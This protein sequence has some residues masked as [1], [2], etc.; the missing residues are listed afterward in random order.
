MRMRT[1]WWGALGAGLLVLTLACAGATKDGGPVQPA[2]TPGE[3][4]GAVEEGIPEAAQKSGGKI[5][6]GIEFPPLRDVRIPE[7]QREVLS[8]GMILFTLKDDELPLVNARAV[9]RTGSVYEPAAQV[10]LASIL[11]TVM[12]T[13]GT[14]AHSGDELDEILEEIAAS[15]ETRISTASGSAALSC[16]KEDF[17]QVLEIF[18]DVLMHP[19]LPQEKIDLAKMQIR[20]SISRRNDSPRSIVSREF[21]KLVYGAESPYA[22]T[23]EYATI[24]AIQRED[25]AAFHN[26]YFHSDRVILSVW[27]DID[28]EEVRAK[29]EAAFAGWEKSG[30]VAP[31]PPPQLTPTSP[32][33]VNYVRKADVNQ[34]SLRIG[35][36]GLRRDNPDYYAVVVMNRILGGGFSSRLFVAVRSKKGFAYSVGSFFRVPFFRRGVFAL[37]CQTKSHSTHAAITAILEEA[38]RIR[39]EEVTDD[40]LQRAKESI[41]NSFVFNFDTPGEII[42]RRMDLEYYGYPLDLLEQYRKGIAAVTKDAIRKAAEKYIRPEKFTILAVGRSE[43]FDQPLD[44][45]GKVNVIDIEIP[46]PP[47][48]ELPEATA[49]AEQMGLELLA[50]AVE[51]HGGAERISEITSYRARASYKRE[52]APGGPMVE[53]ERKLTIHFPDKVRWE[54]E[55]PKGT[56]TFALNGAEGWVQMPDQ[57]ILPLPD[58][59]KK[60]LSEGLFREAISILGGF[61]RPGVKVQLLQGKTETTAATVLLRHESGASVKALLDRESKRLVGLSYVKTS[62]QMGP[63]EFEDEL[64]DFQEVSGVLL[65]LACSTKSLQTGEVVVTVEFGD[66]EIN[67]ELPDDLFR[68]PVSEAEEEALPEE[69][70]PPEEG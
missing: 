30:T 1:K 31:P 40:E 60:M 64:S 69:A 66:V 12:R 63:Q 8:N 42:G 38:E 23:T 16:L 5:H 11:G 44:S 21:S 34:T 22:R 49:E 58:V 9:I 50:E 36:Q 68:K 33:G 53:Q 10:G 70:P 54:Q 13:G 52:A 56:T 25:L 37:Y 17:G 15:V 45:F 46:A 47:R 4:A 43:D 20:S 57:P 27:G 67:P 62:P 3:T 26:D 55:T 39:R 18:A 28:P 35:H 59:F 61:R 6:E 2:E 32:P 19:S 7:I 14:P 48:E 41:D 51:A 65:P 24:D 29:V